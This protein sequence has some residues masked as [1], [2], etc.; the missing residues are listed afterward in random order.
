MAK[1][2]NEQQPHSFKRKLENATYTVKVHFTT[3]I[4]KQEKDRSGK[5]HFGYFI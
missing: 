5:N 2:K 1:T 4:R 3:L